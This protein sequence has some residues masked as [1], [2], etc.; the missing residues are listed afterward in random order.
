MG[1]CILPAHLSFLYCPGMALSH[2]VQLPWCTG[3]S[4]LPTHPGVCTLFQQQ[5]GADPCPPFLILHTAF[6]LSL[7]ITAYT[8]HAASWRI[9][10]CFW[11]KEDE[12]AFLGGLWGRETLWRPD[13]A[14]CSLV[15]TPEAQTCTYGTGLAQMLS[16]QICIRSGESVDEQAMQA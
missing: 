14:R 11:A 7:Q 6:S 15:F 10:W 16:V 2:P 13:R 12:E 3:W 8:G 5:W 9:F 1:K 4:W